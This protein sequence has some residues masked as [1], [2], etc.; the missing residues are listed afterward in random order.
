MFIQQE[1]IAII[2][3]MP[4]VACDNARGLLRHIIV[5]GIERRD[6]NLRHNSSF[7]KPT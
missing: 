5:R 4:R 1:E 3:F 2:Y 7:W 6:I